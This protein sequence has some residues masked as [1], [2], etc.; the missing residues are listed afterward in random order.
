[1]LCN[2]TQLFVRRA[3]YEIVP[4]SFAYF[5]SA[6]NLG[7]Q[8]S[9]RNILNFFI[10]S[11]SRKTLKFNN[12]LHPIT[13]YSTV[14]SQF[15][16]TIPPQSIFSSSCQSIFYCTLLNIDITLSLSF[17]WKYGTIIS[18]LELSFSPLSD[19]NLLLQVT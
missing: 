2:T 1:M 16:H 18:P 19:T 9:I 5:I 12:S 6:Y 17:Q 10:S 8:N 3:L 15:N 14:F 13:Q 7:N 11:L 4:K